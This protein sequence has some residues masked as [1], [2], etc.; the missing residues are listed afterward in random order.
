MRQLRPF[1]LLFLA[2]ASPLLAPAVARAG[3]AAPDSSPP[4]ELRETIE[5]IAAAL[6]A[7]DPEGWERLAQARFTAEELA[8]RTPEQRRQLAVRLH[9]DLGAVAVSAIK[10][11]AP[12]AAEAELRGSAGEDR[13]TLQ[14]E[15]E[16]AP[17]HR[18]R[19]LSMRVERGRGVGQGAPLPPLPAVRGIEDAQGLA[20]LLDPYLSKLAG[21]EVL[22][23]VVMVALHGRPLYSRA[24]GLADRE[25]RTPNTVDTRFNVASIGKQ[26]THVAIGQL[27]AQGKLGLDDPIGKHLPG[28]ANAEAARKVTIRELLEHRAGIPDIFDVVKAGDPP[29]Q[30]NH[31]WFLRVAARPLEFEPGSRSRYCNG[32]YVVLGEIV[33]ALAGTPYEDYLATHVFAPAGMTGTAFLSDADHEGRK[34]RGYTGAPGS[35]APASLGAGGRGSGAGGVF[36]T[37]ADLVRYDDA[38]RG[39]RLLDRQRTAWLLGG[40]ESSGE[41]AAGGLA[42][43]GGAPGANTVLE[44]D[45]TWTI[46]VL[47]N[48]DPS[49]G[50]KLG[51]ALARALGE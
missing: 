26:F 4:A 31:E 5:A 17:P 43:G 47:T 24:F 9:E 13:C 28:Y 39:Y 2:F 36:S 6:S 3:E 37:A 46:V 23:G 14:V 29:P 33:A 7:G 25:R 21:D 42:V 45:G 27:L 1:L 51:E 40:A 48:R 49:T 35:L 50:E 15:L 20:R 30:S 16:A 38:L 10:S 22:S 8:R 34:A 41:R 19:K 12:W 18:V 11:T 32:C 44:S